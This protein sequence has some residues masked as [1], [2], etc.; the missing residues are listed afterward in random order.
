MGNVNSANRTA[1]LLLELKRHI[2]T[3]R[4]CTGAVKTRDKDQLCDH[5]IGLILTLAV[6]YDNVIS[7]RL[8]LARKGDPRIYACP[9]VTKH[10]RV[11][12]MTAEALIVV[13]VQDELF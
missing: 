5:T 7:R 9:D 13:G 11:Y 6:T 8:K 3:C 12:A 2:K 1:D 10:G 4:N